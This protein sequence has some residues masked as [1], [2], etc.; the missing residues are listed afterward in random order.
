PVVDNSAATPVSARI[1]ADRARESSPGGVRKGRP[2]NDQ[3]REYSRPCASRMPVSE[4][5]RESTVLAVEKRKLKSTV[6]SPGITLPAPVPAWMFDTCQEVGGK[7][8]L[9]S[10]QRRPVS[11]A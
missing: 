2:D 10:S 11:S 3:S 9:P 1:A 8:S 5:F 4:D 6:T 7:C